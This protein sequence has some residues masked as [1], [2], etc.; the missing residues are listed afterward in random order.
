MINEKNL[1]EYKY[2]YDN[3]NNNVNTFDKIMLMII[4]WLQL[5]IT[6]FNTIIWLAYELPSIYLG[7]STTNNKIKIWIYNYIC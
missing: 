7:K 1:K 2:Q 5:N 4:I 3:N 6:I